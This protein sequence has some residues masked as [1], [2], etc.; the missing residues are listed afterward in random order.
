MGVWQRG[1]FVEYGVGY[2]G[3]WVL[4]NV[5]VFTDQLGVLGFDKSEFVVCG[6]GGGGGGRGGGG[7]V[8]GAGGVGDVVSVMSSGCEGCSVGK[9]NVPKD[10]PKD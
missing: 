1:K 2:D 9:P 6:G 3:Q 7:D 8:G 4:Q 10:Y 5:G